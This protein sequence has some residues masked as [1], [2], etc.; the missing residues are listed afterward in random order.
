M[1]ATCPVCFNIAGPGG[2][3]LLAIKSCGHVVCVDC[4][5]QIR[6]RFIPSLCHLCRQPFRPETDLV[7]VRFKF[8]Q[9]GYSISL[10]NNLVRRKAVRFLEDRDTIAAERE[11]LRA[12]KQ[13]LHRRISVQRERIQAHED[14]LRALRER[15]SASQQ[16]IAR[17]RLAM[18]QEFAQISSAMDRLQTLVHV[19]Y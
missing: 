15:T 10:F 12:S 9:H 17:L 7:H 6:R 18:R 2:I 13:T 1:L 5:K 8:G 3:Q 14:S 16:E 19:V 11:R 4:F